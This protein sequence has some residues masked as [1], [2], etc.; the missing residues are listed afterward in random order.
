MYVWVCVCVYVYLSVALDRKDS[1]I[2]DYTYHTH[3]HG[4]IHSC[5]II[6]MYMQMYVH[7]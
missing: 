2:V 6:H 1:S 5:E 7:V 3:L 4:D